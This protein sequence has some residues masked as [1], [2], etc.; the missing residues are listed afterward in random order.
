MSKLMQFWQK[1]PALLYGLAALIATALALSSNVFLLIP[2]ALLCTSIITSKKHCICVLAIACAFFIFSKAHITFPNISEDGLSGNAYV[3]ISSV[4]VQS[5]HFGKRWRYKVTLDMADE[6]KNLPC[7]ITFK[8]GNDILRPPA[9][10]AYMVEGVLKKSESDHYYFIPTKDKPWIPVNGT[11]S[12][13][14]MRFHAKQKVVQYI[15]NHIPDS[16]SATFLAGIA[17]GDFDDRTMAFEF[18]RFGLQHIMAI[19]GFHFAI[20]AGILNTVL[21]LFMNR[22]AATFLLILALSSYFLFLGSTPSIFRAWIAVLIALWGFW[23]E[24]KG[25]GLNSLGIALLLILI[26]DPYAVKNIGFQ[27]SFVTTAAILILFKKCDLL[28]QICFPVRPLSQM[29]QMNMFNQ[30]G[31]CFLAY[32]RQ[33]FALTTAVNAVAIPMMVFYFQQFPVMSLIYNLFFPFLVSIS[34]LLLIVSC[35]FFIIPPISDLFHVLNSYYTG[36]VLNFTYHMPPSV[37]VVL[38][39]SGF[40][41]NILISY[42]IVLFVL[43]VMIEEKETENQFMAFI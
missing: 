43:G 1:N 36:F 40:H 19:S 30:H 12:L 6:V 37:D 27:L 42:L 13:A 10:C 8:Q 2:F 5:T 18:S 28:W 20:I 23:M 14:E 38:K 17:T 32:F 16:R 22:K 15:R 21:R 29:I 3:T 34:M 4:G 24:R 33:A 35:L 41:E 25:S 39:L 31:Y 9:N 26:F 7:S 11:W